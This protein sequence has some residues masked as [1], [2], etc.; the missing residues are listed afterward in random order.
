MIPSKPSL[1][2]AVSPATGLGV[3]VGVVAVVG[4]FID[5]DTAWSFVND[6]E[7]DRNSGNREGRDPACSMWNTL[8]L[9]RNL[10]EKIGNG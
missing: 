3:V 9:S 2:A 5:V 10:G 1:V 7:D 4:E 8:R 6:G